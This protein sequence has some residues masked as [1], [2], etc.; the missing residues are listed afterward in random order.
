MVTQAPLC[1]PWAGPFLARTTEESCWPGLLCS[2]PRSG[3]YGRR[4]QRPGCLVVLSSRREG[5]KDGGLRWRAEHSQPQ[6]KG[7]EILVRPRGPWER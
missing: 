1:L 6:K 7:Q 3:G 2:L 4:E 5:D